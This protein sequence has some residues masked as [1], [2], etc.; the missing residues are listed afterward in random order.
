[1]SS[2]FHWGLSGI[3]QQN[4]SGLAN[5]LALR[6]G[7]QQEPLAEDLMNLGDDDLRLE[8]EAASDSLSL[9]SARVQI[10]ATSGHGSLKS[11]F[12]DRLAELMSRAKGGAH[13]A[14]TAMRER[15]DDITLW[16]TRNTG[17]KAVDKEFV[18]KFQA[19]LQSISRREANGS[20]SECTTTNTAVQ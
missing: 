18:E 19:M 17:F 11:H 14:C 4:F 3:N 15:E 13:V 9:A 8:D 5:L 12:L 6:N 10:I 2:G 1:M 20:E 16:V 7:G